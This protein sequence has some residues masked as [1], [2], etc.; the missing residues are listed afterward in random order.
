M[1]LKECN[2]FG[3]GPSRKSYVP[4][5]LPSIG[6]NFPWTKVQSTLMIDTEAIDKLCLNTSLIEVE[7][8]LILHK[9]IYYYLLQT[10]KIHLLK[11]KI[12][13]IFK[14]KESTQKFKLSSGHNACLYMISNG[15]N[16]LNIYGCDNFFGDDTC[17]ENI[18]HDKSLPN[19]IENA[20]LQICSIDVLTERGIFW[21]G[22]WHKMIKQYPHVEFNFI[23]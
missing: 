11:N 22:Y 5:D 16:K 19:Y 21:R 15:F 9:D 14:L 12:H 13:S 3:S 23:K 4:N 2:I 8:N 7:T 1:K 20:F 10:N 18:S 6:C 17:L